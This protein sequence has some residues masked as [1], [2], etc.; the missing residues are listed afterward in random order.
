MSQWAL[1]DANS[2]DNLCCVE[3][4][5]WEIDEIK[6]YLFVFII[7]ASAYLLKNL[8]KPIVRLLTAHAYIVVYGFAA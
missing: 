5:C 7:G 1:A 6:P 4:F 2:M 3:S 8:L